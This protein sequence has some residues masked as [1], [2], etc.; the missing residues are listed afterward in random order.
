MPRRHSDRTR[1]PQRPQRPQRPQSKIDRFASFA[2]FAF[3]VVA[4]VIMV[5]GWYFRQRGP[6][7][8]MRSGACQ[9]CNVLL[10]T[11][12]TLRLD[13]VGAFGGRLGLTPTLDRLAS[14]GFRLTRA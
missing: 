9:G 13:R 8:S 12:D 3:I 11:I 5:G 2:I 6:H 14:E 10:I 7:P 4:A 1:S